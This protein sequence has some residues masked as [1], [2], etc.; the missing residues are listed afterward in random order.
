MRARLEQ[1]HELAGGEA[2]P[3]MDILAGFQAA[4]SM[5][6][7]PGGRPDQYEINFIAAGAF[8]EATDPEGS[9]LRAARLT[10]RAAWLAVCSESP[11]LARETN[12]DLTTAARLKAKARAAGR[13]VVAAIGTALGPRATT[14]QQ[15]TNVAA[16][17]L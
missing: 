5:L 16:R 12:P 6:R 15:F 7:Q 10:G 1:R 2:D 11:S 14:F 17:S 8:R 9:R 3:D 13:T 4:L